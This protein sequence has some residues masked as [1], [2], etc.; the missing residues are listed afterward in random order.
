M[1]IKIDSIGMTLGM[2]AAVQE[3]LKDRAID[4]FH[5][6]IA[7]R[8]PLSQMVFDPIDVMEVERLRKPR[9]QRCERVANT[10]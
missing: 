10:E 4:I 6:V 8:G 1:P 5:E 9:S 2:E 3:G 7:R